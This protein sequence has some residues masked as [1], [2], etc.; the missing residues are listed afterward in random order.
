MCGIIFTATFV[1]MTFVSMWMFRVMKN[2]N[3]LRI[4]CVLCLIGG[5]VRQLS[6]FYGFWPVLLG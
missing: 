5:W 1:P 2:H 4:A 3:V 6:T